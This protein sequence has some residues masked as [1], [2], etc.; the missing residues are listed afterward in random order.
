METVD[1]KSPWYK[2]FLKNPESAN[3]YIAFKGLDK[4][5]IDEW[6]YNF[7]SGRADLAVKLMKKEK[8]LV[9][10]FG[11]KFNYK[12]EHEL[13]LSLHSQSKFRIF[14]HFD[15][16]NV[17]SQCNFDQPSIIYPAR[18]LNDSQPGNEFNLKGIKI[19]TFKYCEV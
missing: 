4:L 10:K 6:K 19:F 17:K 15:V 14:L 16:V 2:K 8:K 13:F 18:P 12:K 7:G 9:L 1:F 3:I 5:K 11:P